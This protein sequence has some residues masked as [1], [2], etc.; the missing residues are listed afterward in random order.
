MGGNRL[1]E[2]Y[3]KAFADQLTILKTEFIV[4]YRAYIADP[5]GMAKE[6]QNKAEYLEDGDTGIR[7]TGLELDKLGRITD[8]LLQK[9]S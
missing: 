9:A 3:G 5:N 4:G 7:E 8:E 2:V 1:L 6:P